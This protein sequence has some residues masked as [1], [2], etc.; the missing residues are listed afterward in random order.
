MSEATALPTEPQPLPYDS[1]SL[2][3]RL[4][5]KHGPQEKV[6]RWKSSFSKWEGL[7]NATDSVTVSWRKWWWWWYEGWGSV[8]KLSRAWIHH[9]KIC[10][11]FVALENLL[12]G[13]H[14]N[15]YNPC[16]F[17]KLITDVR[18]LFNVKWRS[19][20]RCTFLRRLSDVDEGKIW[21]EKQKF[22]VQG[23][24]SNLEKIESNFDA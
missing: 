11:T 22:L 1:L 4:L 16:V 24:T 13:S 21:I 18:G 8:R 20:R 12:R 15:V 5:Y 2:W 9:D 3:P 23:W 10:T 6:C 14:P 19:W 7:N 17:S